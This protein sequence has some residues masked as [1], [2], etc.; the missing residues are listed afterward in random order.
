M[1]GYANAQR[2][3]NGGYWIGMTDE[4]AKL[5]LGNP[6]EINRTTDSWGVQEQWVYSGKNLYLYFENGK[7]TSI[8][9]NV[10]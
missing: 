1:F 5:S 9:E 10:R 7:L 6:D 8:Q 2:I 3:K 4:M